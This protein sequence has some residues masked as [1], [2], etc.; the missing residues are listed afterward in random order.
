MSL[1]PLLLVPVADALPLVAIVATITVICLVQ[2]WMVLETD[3]AGPGVFLIA[4][5]DPGLQQFEPAAETLP[6]GRE[7]DGAQGVSATG[8]ERLREPV[9]SSSVGPLSAG[10]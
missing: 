2:V 10:G 5:V 3:S 9:P 7:G 1:L 4:R 6:P 8:H